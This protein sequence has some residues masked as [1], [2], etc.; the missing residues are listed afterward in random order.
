MIKQVAFAFSVSVAFAAT[1]AFAQS[2][3]NLEKL[4]AFKTT[5]SG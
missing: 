4:G 3:D 5:C 1:S 2:N